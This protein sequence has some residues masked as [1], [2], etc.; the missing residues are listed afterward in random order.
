MSQFTDEEKASL[1]TL[2][3][4]AAI[5]RFDDAMQAVLDN[6]VDPNAKVG[7]RT[8]TLKVTIKPDANGATANVLIECTPKLQPAHPC[9]TLFYIGKQAGHGMAF[10][11]N[12]EQLNMPF[13]Q[14]T[15]IQGGKAGN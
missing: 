5:E 3:K 10:E 14:P 1:L 13:P 11:H 4:G 12:P 2:A 9:T 8:V 15:A 6:I 7:A